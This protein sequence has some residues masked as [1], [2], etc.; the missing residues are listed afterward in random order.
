MQLA[1]P[2]LKT[3]LYSDT[4]FSSTTST[5]GNTCAQL[6]TTDQHFTTV[7]PMKTKGLAYEAFNKF[8]K[9]IGIPQCIL[10]D[11]AGE[12]LGEQWQRV[13]RT[14]L[15]HQRTT[16]PYS[17]WQNRA[18]IEIGELRRHFRRIMHQHRVPEE[19]WD[20]ALEYTSRL[21]LYMSRI[22]LDGRSAWETLTGDTP[23]I[24]EYKE[25]TF[26][27]FATYMTKT[28]RTIDY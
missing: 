28:H 13:R 24:S 20:F 14:Y 17:G 4:M 26:T 9:T 19:L 11:N 15:I 6:F 2:Q 8:C 25:F 10:T 1:Y 3:S 18:E 16:E 12:E 23:D 7:Y 21:R 22:N 5:R 27:N